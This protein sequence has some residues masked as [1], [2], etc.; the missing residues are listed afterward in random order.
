MPDSGSDTNLNERVLD[1]MNEP[2]HYGVFIDRSTNS[3]I[4]DAGLSQTMEEYLP[5]TGL[6][7]RATQ[8]LSENQLIG[9]K[10]RLGYRR[11]TILL[12]SEE[13]ALVVEPKV[14]EGPFEVWRGVATSA[15]PEAISVNWRNLAGGGLSEKTYRRLLELASLPKGW[16]GRGSLS[17]N[18]SSLWSFI[19]FWKQ[20]SQL[21]VE[22]DLVLTPNGCVQAEWGKDSRHYLEIDF[23][24]SRENSFFALADGR[25]TVI[26]GA[27]SLREILRIIKSYKNAVAL[28]W[29][30]E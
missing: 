24:G 25:R 7:F 27:T 1:Y 16:N 14:H 15:L 26:E 8:P 23:R 2:W 20:I 21:S 12:T 4:S 5:V 10:S 29:Q 19:A 13:T 17:M 28:T 30:Y 9:L 6:R 11:P 22:P 18:A 3:T